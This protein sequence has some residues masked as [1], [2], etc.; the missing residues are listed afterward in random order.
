MDQRVFYRF[1]KERVLGYGTEIQE[2]FGMPDNH[3]ICVYEGNAD[4][5]ERILAKILDI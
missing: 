4:V 2:S 1:L 3:F 5:Q